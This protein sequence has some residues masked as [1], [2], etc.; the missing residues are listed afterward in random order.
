[1]EDNAKILNI[2]LLDILSVTLSGNPG[3]QLLVYR[4]ADD[5]SVGLAMNG[6]NE[7][8]YEYELVGGVAYR[9]YIVGYYHLGPD[10]G[11]DVG[12]M[13]AVV[14]MVIS[15]ICGTAVVVKKKEF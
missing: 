11:G 8:T 12:F 7:T 6:T 13:G 2:H 15:A 10:E 1:M 14:T 4:V 5:G 9:V 3:Y